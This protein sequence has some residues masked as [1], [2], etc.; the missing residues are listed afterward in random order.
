GGLA[1]YCRTGDGLRRRVWSKYRT[2]TPKNSRPSATS[3]NTSKR[4]RLSS[5]ATGAWCVHDCVILCT[6]ILCTSSTVS[7]EKRCEDAL[8]SQSTSCE[9]HAELWSIS[10]QLCSEHASSRR[11]FAFFY[12]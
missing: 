9:I 10:R 2:K 12:A 1:G 3:S 7:R 8:H 11:I 6:S 4:N 5:S